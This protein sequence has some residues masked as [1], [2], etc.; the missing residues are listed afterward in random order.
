M[1]LAE[2]KRVRPQSHPWNSCGRETLDLACFL[3]LGNEDR[4]GVGEAVW[5]RGCWNNAEV[6]WFQKW[7]VSQPSCHTNL[8]EPR[9]E[10]KGRGRGWAS[11]GEALPFGCGAGH[12][13]APKTQM[14]GAT[15]PSLAHSPS[16]LPPSKLLLQTSK[17]S[18]DRAYLKQ[19]PEGN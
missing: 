15:A 13:P 19:P 18:K 6:C 17:G 5:A 9:V 8:L 10:A 14:K 3:S 4:A 2:H 12:T 7:P 1:P 16:P 11:E